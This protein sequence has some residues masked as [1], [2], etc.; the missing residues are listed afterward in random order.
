[1][2]RIWSH[3]VIKSSSTDEPSDPLIILAFSSPSQQLL[4]G[5]IHPDGA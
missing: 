1:M 2:N 3:I 5:I 4:F